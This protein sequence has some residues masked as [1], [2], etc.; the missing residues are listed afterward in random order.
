[1]K[2]DGRRVFAQ[3]FDAAKELHIAKAVQ[4]RRKRA[5]P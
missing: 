4:L 2:A 3:S 1:M 5:M